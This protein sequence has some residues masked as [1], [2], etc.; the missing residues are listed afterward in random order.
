ML[1]ASH[2][3]HLRYAGLF[4]AAAGQYPIVVIVLTWVAVNIPNFTHR[5]TIST[6]TNMLAQSITTAVLTTFDDAPYY[7]KGLSVVI[8]L[9]CCN[10]NSL[11]SWCDVLQAI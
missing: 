5:A 7:H 10:P 2:N 1:I 9:T 4:L 6:I 11:S 3:N 8:G